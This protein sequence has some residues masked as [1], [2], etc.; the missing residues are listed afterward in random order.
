V[1]D[2]IRTFLK[3]GV[4]DEYGIVQYVETLVRYIYASSVCG[5]R[6]PGGTGW[7][8]LPENGFTKAPPWC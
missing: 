5:E 4:W 2:L 3:F 1:R 6:C 8:S 7:K